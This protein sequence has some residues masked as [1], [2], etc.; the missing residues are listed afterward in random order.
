MPPVYA[1]SENAYPGPGNGLPVGVSARILRKI[2]ELVESGATVLGPKPVRAPGLTGYPHCDEEVRQLADE[3]W[4]ETGSGTPGER[5][6]GKGRVIWGKRIED[7]L[8]KDGVLPDFTFRSDRL[9]TDL[10]YIHYTLEG[11]EFY[12]ISN[13]N[14]RSEKVECRFRVSDMQPELWDAVTGEMHTLGRFRSDGGQTAVPMEFAPRQSFFVVFRK[15]ANS[16]ISRGKERRNFPRI[17]V[18]REIRGPWELSFDPK[19]GGPEKVTFNTLQDWTQRPEEGIRY[20]SGTATYR[21]SF[22]LP[23]KVTGRRLFLDLGVVNYLAAVRVN[24]KDLGVVWTAPWRVEITHAVKLHDN[25]LE[26]DVVNLWTNRL[27]GDAKL[28]PEKRFTK[29]NV[30]PDP[31]WQLFSS[32]ACWVRSHCR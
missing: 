6:V 28:P 1:S 8:E 10:R 4:G 24:G 5:T 19:W 23:E 32:G 25:S 27:I 11:A 18:V 7:I 22:D 13:Q 3:L 17:E 9:W 30:V 31:D 14:L 29:T 2:K 21:Q 26:I 20:Y 16:G 12:F 15:P